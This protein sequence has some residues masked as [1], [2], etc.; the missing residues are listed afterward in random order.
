M[1]ISNRTIITCASLAFVVLL[2]LVPY[3]A[4]M[5]MIRGEIAPKGNGRQSVVLIGSPFVA[6]WDG[7]PPEQSSKFSLTWYS[8]PNEME[9]RS[10]EKVSV[11][12]LNE[13][14]MIKGLNSNWNMSQVTP[15]VSSQLST[16]INTTYILETN[17][18]YQHFKNDW[19]IENDTT[20]DKENNPV[21][22]VG[23]YILIVNEYGNYTQYYLKWQTPNLVIEGLG[24]FFSNFVYV[25]LFGLAFMLLY[26]AWKEH[27]NPDRKG[28]ASKYRNY[29]VSMVCGGIVTLT[30]QLF[31]W[32]RDSNPA[33][34]WSGA[35]KFAAMPTWVLGGALSQNLLT[36]VTILCI[37]GSLSVISNTI[38]RDIQKKKIPYFTLALW[39]AE[40]TIITFAFLVT[41]TPDLINAFGVVVYVWVGALA[42]VG[43]NMFVTYLKLCIQTSGH[44]RKK[45]L[46]VMISLL[47]TFTGLILRAWMHPE[48]LA[49]A[50]GTIFAMCLYK[51]LII[52]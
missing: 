35:L 20:L 26:R 13:T 40:L 25:I 38:E 22:T 49:N 31:S 16:W 24:A 8:D 23:F 36:F 18:T 43:A 37:G 47:L 46:L 33:V 32:W 3:C 42:L 29:G 34:D 19:G 14:E 2:F 51:G 21:Y 52:E 17:L 27:K 48:F 4:G 28:L 15:K 30:W 12:V 10:T 45:S 7:K 44:L 6:T 41:W 39:I 1:K 11:Y 50:M 9:I 5:D